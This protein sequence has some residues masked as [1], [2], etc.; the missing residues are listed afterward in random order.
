[1]SEVHEIDRQHGRV[2]QG[3]SMSAVASR[4]RA[5]DVVRGLIMIVMALDHTRDYFGIR[6]NPTDLATARAA[7]FATRLITH[8]CA[9]VFFLLLGTGAYLASRRQSRRELSRYLL[10]RGVWLIFL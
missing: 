5:I 9:P 6:Q 4:L 7:W 1:M 3:S 10:T 2:G 8:I